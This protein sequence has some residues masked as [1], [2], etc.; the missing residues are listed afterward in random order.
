MGGRALRAPSAGD[1]RA[2]DDPERLVAHGAA[3]EERGDGGGLLVLLGAA[4]TLA[5]SANNFRAMKLNALTRAHLADNK[6]DPELIKLTVPAK[7]GECHAFVSHSWSDDGDAKYDRLH[8]WAKGDVDVEAEAWVKGDV[9][10]WLDKACIDQLRIEQSLACL[11]CFLAG[12]R[13]LV[14]LAGPS[15]PTRL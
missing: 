7:L 12:C 10:L 3:A 4:A 9:L 15:Y 8:E 5:E 2:R 14:C 1:E 11:P 13:Q 6:P